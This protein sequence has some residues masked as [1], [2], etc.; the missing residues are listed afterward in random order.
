MPGAATT[1]VKYQSQFGNTLLKQWWIVS[2][3]RE[4]RQYPGFITK[5]LFDDP[6]FEQSRPCRREEHARFLDNENDAALHRQCTVKT[7]F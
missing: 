5:F 2:E 1:E 6:G 7:V 4:A 3:S